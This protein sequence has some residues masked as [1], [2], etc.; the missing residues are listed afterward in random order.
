[1]MIGIISDTHGLLRPEACERL[2]CVDHIIHAGDIGRPEVIAGLRELAPTTAIRGNID[3][4]DTDK[5][6]W[7]RGYP[8]TAR[9]ALGGRS[10]HVLH[11]LKDLDLDPA[12]SSAIAA[13][14]SPSLIAAA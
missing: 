10:I 6:R 4:V 9:L 11:D 1:M 7:A 14:L 12:A 8:H 5:G 3:R 2:A 13:G